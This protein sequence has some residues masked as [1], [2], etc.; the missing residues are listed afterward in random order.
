MGSS[1]L[2]GVPIDET[3]DGG[4]FGGMDPSRFLSLDLAFWFNWRE[5]SSSTN[6]LW[7]FNLLDGFFSF[8]LKSF[9]ISRF[10]PCR[11]VHGGVNGDDSSLDVIWEISDAVVVLTRV[12]FSS[13]LVNLVFMVVF[14]SCLT[15]SRGVATVVEVVS[16]V[17]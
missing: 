1:S 17:W 5:F 13:S 8:S 2:I 11:E 6:F 14:M 10:I 15:P 3:G 12:P 9:I 16:S 4:G 7:V